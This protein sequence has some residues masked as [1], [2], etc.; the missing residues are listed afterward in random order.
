MYLLGTEAP[1]NSRITAA[2]N[3]PHTGYGDT[4][5]GHSVQWMDDLSGFVEGMDR[6]ARRAQEE[7]HKAVIAFVQG[8]EADAASTLGR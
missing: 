1:D 4:G 7:Y 6:A 8:D 3:A 2:C 5:L